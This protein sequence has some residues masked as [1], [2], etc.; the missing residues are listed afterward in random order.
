MTPRVVAILCSALLSLPAFAGERI[1]VIATGTDAQTQ[2]E[3]VLCISQTC[4]APEKVLTSGR[5]DPKKL[6]R[7]NVKL[8]VTGKKA[9]AGLEVT[10]ADLQGGVRY[11]ETVKAGAGAKLSVGTLVT[12]AAE[13]IAA[14]ENPRAAKKEPVAKSQK[15]KLAKSAAKSK[16]A[17]KFAARGGKTRG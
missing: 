11:Q 12:V 17:K 6:Q 14:I 3:E 8:V 16:F 1:A 2:L 5:A 4:V 15:A 13:A 9:G 10:V 7:E